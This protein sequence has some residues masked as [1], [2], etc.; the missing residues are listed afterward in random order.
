MNNYL[1]HHGILGQRWGV[2]RYQNT[3]GSLTAYG[4][5]R[6]IEAAHEA[7]KTNDSL[8]ERKHRNSH[9]LPSKA[10]DKRY[11]FE[12]KNQ[13]ASSIFDKDGNIQ[14]SYL[15]GKNAAVAK[16]KEWCDANLGKY[17]RNPKAVKITYYEDLG[18]DFL[19]KIHDVK[20]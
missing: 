13:I 17:F 1:Q 12:P 19:E 8:A 3:D 9:V 18:K 4:K 20:Y 11:V 10:L 16:G 5:R 6:L 15:H 14:V 2:R 7:Q